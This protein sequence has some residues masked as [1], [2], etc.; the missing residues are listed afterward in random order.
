MIES[1]LLLILSMLFV[2]TLLTMLGNK[3]KISYPVFLVIA[4]LIISMLPGTP[5]I[6]IDPDIVF[7][8]FLPP[9]LFSASM[10]MPWAEFWKLKRRI[11]MLGFGLVF[12][13]STIIAFISTALIPGFTL[14]LGF[15]LGGII[16]PPDAVAATS[17][18]KGLKIPRNIVNLLEA[19]SLVNDASS[20]IVYRFALL[21]VI[22]GSFNAWTATKSFFLVAGMGILIGLVIAFVI[23]LI[24]RFF[25]TT[26]A[27]D[28]AFTLLSPYVMYLVA[29]HFHCSGILS[30][31]AG[32]LFLSYHS[33]RML[34]Y[35]SR[36]STAG[37]WDTL[38]FLLNGFIFILIGLQLPYIV[39]HFTKNTIKEALV[40]GLIIS[41]AVIMI[42]MVWVYASNYIRIRI[43]RKWVP[44]AIVPTHKETFLVAWCGM[45]G[46]VSLAAALA[47]PFSIHGGAEFPYRYLIL[48]IT[49]VVI[50]VTLVLQGLT[51]SPLIQLLKIQD[52]GEEKLK[53]QHQQL[54]LQLSELALAHI[55]RYYKQDL[56]QG[57]PFSLTRNRYKHMIDATKRKLGLV[58]GKNSIADESMPRFRQLML[59]LIQLKRKELMKYRINRTFS[60]D[61][62]KEKEWELDLEE[63]RLKS[64]KG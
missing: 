10:Q 34:S 52:R 44:D 22:S 49:F 25:T 39:A 47:M 28:T 27:I 21:A 36:I 18:L 4:G 61:L 29:E 50:I 45:R 14:A 40:Y 26:S 30:V 53:K 7:L 1:R 31:V 55:D 43:K 3:L 9:V 57:G 11:A 60:E 42:R 2:I 16:S 12:F 5:E 6:K 15:V 35:Q 51:I 17:V 13:T 20:L 23:Y 38:T 62:I 33:H 32:G 58:Q 46:M 54:K 63:A 59:E 8:I 24:L 64:R 37:V 48:F 56:E 41:G 19:E